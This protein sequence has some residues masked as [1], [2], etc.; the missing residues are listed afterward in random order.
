LVTVLGA[1]EIHPINV[2][3]GGSIVVRS[4]EVVFAIDDESGQLGREAIRS[5][6]SSRHRPAWDSELEAGTDVR[7]PRDLLD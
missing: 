4:V 6:V 5:R 2:K 7:R 3:V 1:R